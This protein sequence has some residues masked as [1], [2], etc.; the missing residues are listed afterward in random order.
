LE[1]SH[2]ELTRLVE[3]QGALRRF[4]TLVARGAPP[5]EVLAAVA[6]EL[7]QLVGTDGVNLVRYEADGTATVVG[8]WGW[9]GNL[10][11]LGTNLSLEG[12][13]LSA[14]VLHSGRPARIDSYAD[15]AGPLAT[16][17]REHGI[18]SAI[19]APMY[20][21]GRLWGAVTASMTR[22]ERLPD[23]SEAC[24]AEYSDLIATAV[25]N[26][27]ARDDLAASRARVV[28]AADQARRRIERDLHD[29]IQ[30]RLVSLALDVRNVEASIPSEMS[31]PR[32]RLS[33]VADGLTGAL[34][35]LREIS[36]GIHPAILSEG[37][38][39]PALKA[40]ARRSAVPVDLDLRLERRLPE[41]V[42]IAAYYVVAETLTNATKHA[43]ASLVR[44]DA[45]IRDDRLHLSVEDDGV[46]GADPARGSGL[47]GLTDRVEALSGTIMISSPAGHGTSLQVELPLEL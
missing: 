9:L 28:L 14:M 39:R 38:L 7:G 3:T 46:G 5:S 26:A 10:L 25:A 16:Y 2:D 29:G 44:I 24:L 6:T 35:D 1:R 17:L 11:P 32:E 34:D 13:S 18:G 36:R 12:R 15:V 23:D 41:P 30:Q 47:I 42:E 19:G 37:G 20:V 43:N 4:A 27:Q 33:A 31:E 8:S 22:G 40:L 45:A 21:E